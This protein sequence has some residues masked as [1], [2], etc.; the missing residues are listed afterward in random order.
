[1]AA[2]FFLRFGFS[3]AV[4]PLLRGFNATGGIRDG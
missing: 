2:D 4:A 3:S 1:L